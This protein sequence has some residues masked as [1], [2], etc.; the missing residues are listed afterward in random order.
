MNDALGLIEV[1]GLA[2]AINVA[3]TMAKVASVEL[4]GIEKA[5]G[6][7]WMTVKVSGN[8]GAVNAAIDAGTA[9]AN[10]SQVF[11]AAKVI[12]RPAQGLS[13]EFLK[14]DETKKKQPTSEKKEKAEQAP[15]SQQS[16]NDL[17]DKQAPPKAAPKDAPKPDEKKAATGSQGASEKKTQDSKDVKSSTAAEKKTQDSKV[18]ESSTS[19]STGKD[20]SKNT[21][22]TSKSTPRPKQTTTSNKRSQASSTTNK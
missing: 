18:A 10:E 7:G 4:L 13:N 15:K 11:V 22:S 17:K 5:R 3:D 2:A 1:K 16:Q 9:K 21:S 6:S 12:P 14:S 20:T 19:E 8:V